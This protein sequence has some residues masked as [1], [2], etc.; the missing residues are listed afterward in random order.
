MLI[1]RISPSDIP[2]VYDCLATLRGDAQYDEIEFRRYIEIND[3]FNPGP[4]S[5]FVGREAGEQV[6]MLTSN[7]FSIPRYLGFGVDIEEVIVHPLYQG[8]GL[9]EK[10]LNGLIAILSL[11]MS[12]RKVVVK[13]DDLQRAGKVYERCFSVS[14]QMVYA[15]AINRL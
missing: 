11:D 5:I 7:R 2:F 12:I 14:D 10:M 9:A 8:K 15:R 4:F 13:T 1:Q 3:L 6:G